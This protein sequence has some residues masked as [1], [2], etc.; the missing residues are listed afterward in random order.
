MET[1]EN[2][3]AFHDVPERKGVSD[4]WGKSRKIDVI[5]NKTVSLFRVAG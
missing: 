1:P 4:E 5:E 2:T 3:A